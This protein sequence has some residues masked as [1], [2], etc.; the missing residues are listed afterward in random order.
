MIH[1]E[2]VITSNVEMITPSQKMTRG[3]A[4]K[5]QTHATIPESK[6]ENKRSKYKRSLVSGM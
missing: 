1:D 3:D 2:I 6:G 4:Q 5:S